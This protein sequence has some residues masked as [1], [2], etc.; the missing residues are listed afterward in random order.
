LKEHS[1]KKIGGKIRAEDCTCCEPKCPAKAVAFWPVCDPDI[2]S[3]PYCREH[4]DKAKL[5]LM[6]A[7][8]EI[9][10]PPAPR[11]LKLPKPPKGHHT[12]LDCVGGTG[13]KASVETIRAG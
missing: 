13:C 6:L 10:H 4:L 8:Y 2:P 3:Y 9:D 1:P 12:V 7:I 5:R 11:K